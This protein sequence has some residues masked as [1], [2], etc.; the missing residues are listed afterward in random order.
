[1]KGR[2]RGI[3]AREV[4]VCAEGGRD[5]GHGFRATW[6]MLGERLDAA[7][8][9]ERSD[10]S[11]A[12]GGATICREHFTVAMVTCPAGGASARATAEV[13]AWPTFGTV[14]IESLPCASRPQARPDQERVEGKQGNGT[15]EVRSELGATQL[16]HPGPALPHQLPG[17]SMSDSIVC[18]RG[19]RPEARKEATLRSKG[20]TPGAGQEV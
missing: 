4:W 1:M 9:D 16:E 5:I 12:S 20:A 11:S 2:A 10:A 17:E 15:P 8:F 19:C 3:A 18:L 7:A 13:V 14:D 6:A